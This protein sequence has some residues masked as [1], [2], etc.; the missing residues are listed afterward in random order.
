M[1]LVGR[2]VWCGN[3]F[4][5][6]RPSRS[7]MLELR[8]S[9]LGDKFGAA[10]TTRVRA[11]RPRPGNKWHLDN[12]W[13]RSKVRGGTCG[14]PSTSTVRPWGSWSPPGGATWP[15]AGSYA[16]CWP[17][18]STYRGCWSPTSC[19]P[20]A[21]SRRPPACDRI[22]RHAPG[23]ARRTQ[24][25][26]VEGQTPGPGSR[27]SSLSGWWG[28]RASTSNSSGGISGSAARV[29]RCGCGGRARRVPA[30]MELAVKAV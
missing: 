5:C 17:A 14:G 10:Y 6:C 25:G 28:T 23:R 12:S 26:L 3:Q 22:G 4:G 20:H 24:A 1:S 2:P 18:S 15:P 27:T 13:C 19:A 21:G 11:R 9:E 16:S 30:G 8:R 29:G 7:P